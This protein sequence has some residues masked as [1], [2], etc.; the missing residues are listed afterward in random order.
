MFE[1]VIAVIGDSQLRPA[2]PTKILAPQTVLFPDPFVAVIYID[3]H[4]QLYQF[5][6]EVDCIPP[7]SVATLLTPF[8]LF[9]SEQLIFFGR[10]RVPQSVKLS[11][12][13]K[14]INV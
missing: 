13:L 9:I 6:E 11:S 7:Y 1:R 12:V 8:A 4:Y 3:G 2:Q 10:P 5:F 14:L